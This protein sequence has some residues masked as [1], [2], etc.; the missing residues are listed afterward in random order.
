MEL[1]ILSV[2]SLGCLS[3]SLAEHPHHRQA[4][5][6]TFAQQA[7][8]TLLVQAKQVNLP[9]GGKR[10][11]TQAAADHGHLS[12]RFTSLAPRYFYIFTPLVFNQDADF[13]SDDHIHLITGFVLLEDDF[14]VQKMLFAC[15][16]SN[17]F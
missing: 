12:N 17:A 10:C 4:D 2:F 11:A 9:R 5:L 16:S 14:A 3:Q 8:E 15:D 1:V 7:L 13:S 6:R